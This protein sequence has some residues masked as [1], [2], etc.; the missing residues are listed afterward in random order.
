M[1]SY[2]LCSVRS[3]TS[4]MI[5]TAQ[6]GTKMAVAGERQRRADTHAQAQ[7]KCGKETIPDVLDIRYG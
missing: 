1:S 6:S 4:E 5:Y 3:T 7:M 2:S